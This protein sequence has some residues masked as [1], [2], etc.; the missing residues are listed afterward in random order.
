M[1]FLGH[2]MSVNG[3]GVMPLMQRAETWLKI[4]ASSLLSGHLDLLG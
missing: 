3:Q 1:I 2:A 4:K